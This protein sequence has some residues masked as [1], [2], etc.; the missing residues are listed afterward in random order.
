MPGALLTGS[1][2]VLEE[3]ACQAED[4]AKAVEK[5]RAIVDA[6]TI[7]PNSDSV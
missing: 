4:A 2:I 5:V 6:H 1:A 7:T 3:D